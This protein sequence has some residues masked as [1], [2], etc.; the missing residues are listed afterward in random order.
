MVFRSRNASRK[1]SINA[2]ALAMAG[3]ITGN[4]ADKLPLDR[5]VDIELEVELVAAE[6]ACTAPVIVLLPRREDCDPQECA[7]P[8][9]G[10]SQRVRRETSRHKPAASTDQGY[11]SS[12][13]APLPALRQ[14]DRRRDNESSL[15]AVMTD[16]RR[17]GQL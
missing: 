5:A 4:H 1:S 16:C 15:R 12:R 11:R 2:P 9:T 6:R 3:F 8:G 13:S 10:E 14:A 17:G 7:A